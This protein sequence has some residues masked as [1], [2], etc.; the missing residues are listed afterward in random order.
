MA[1]IITTVPTLVDEKDTV[2]AKQIMD[3]IHTAI[4]AYNKSNTAEA[5]AKASADSANNAVA[6]ANNA[7]TKANN[8][9]TAA[10]VAANDAERSASDAASSASLAEQARANS[11]QSMQEA[12]RSADAAQ[13]AQ[14][15]AEE[16]QRKANN[17]DF[18]GRSITSVSISGA[19]DGNSGASNRYNVNSDDPNKPVLGTF[20]VTN[21][22]K[23]ADGTSVSVSSTL[24]EFT[25]SQY[26]TSIPNSGWS[27][28]FPSVGQG[29]FLW[30][31]TTVNFSDGKSSVSYSVA[32][33][34]K[35]GTNGIDGAGMQKLFDYTN[36][37]YGYSMGEYLESL[38]V[39]ATY[40]FVIYDTTAV[41]ENRRT[42]FAIATAVSD[43]ALSG[44]Y[45]IGTEQGTFD[46]GF[47]DGYFPFPKPVKA[48]YRLT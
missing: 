28:T 30:T 36:T 9:V 45:F 22:A 46:S 25:T 38:P 8:A 5:N 23:G 32:R 14:A 10:E 41:L 18:N 19:F 44:S 12:G 34:G 26:G 27:T 35:D 43:I 3:T 11:A 16:V 40:L 33:Q 1:D 48:I 17:G 7:V 15:A 4:T 6:N 37:S 24:T 39:K 31:R 13:A 21:G 2:T 42:G 20:T 47:S 29:M